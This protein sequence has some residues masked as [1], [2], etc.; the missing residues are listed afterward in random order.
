MNKKFT[1]ELISAFLD[2]E[3]TAEEK[4]FVEQ[5]LVDSAE[6]R[7]TFEELRALRGSL[8]SL[9]S[10]N[11]DDGFSERIL[12]R[13]ERVMLSGQTPTSK[14]E[15]TDK[16][17]AKAIQHDRGNWRVAVVVVSSVAAA[18]FISLFCLPPQQGDST[19]MGDSANKVAK[20][21]NGP[22]PSVATDSAEKPLRDL[23]LTLHDEN[24]NGESSNY[25]GLG[26]VAGVGGKSGEL[27]SDSGL[28]ELSDK[29]SG[30]LRYLGVATDTEKPTSDQPNAAEGAELFRQS[31]ETKERVELQQS[32]VPSAAKQSKNAGEP[33]GDFANSSVANPAADSKTPADSKTNAAI[34]SLT[35]AA[36]SNATFTCDD[37]F[38]AL[39]DVP[40][41]AFEKGAFDQ[42]LLANGIK[43]VSAQRKS[44]KSDEVADSPATDSVDVSA[45]APAT[46]PTPNESFDNNQ[47]E[48]AKAAEHRE[49]RQDVDVVF[50][51]ATME[52]IASTFSKLQQ[53]GYLL[54]QTVYREPSAGQVTS[55]YF[56]LQRDN[57]LMR[58]ESQQADR[59][60]VQETEEAG[61]ARRSDWPAPDDAEL[62][63]GKVKLAGPRAAHE[64]TAATAD[65]KPHAKREADNVSEN[66][67]ID[68][69]APAKHGIAVRV[70][71]PQ[72]P[73]QEFFK[74]LGQ[75]SPSGESKGD[76]QSRPLTSPGAPSAA[77]DKKSGAEQLRENRNRIANTGDADG[78]GL[79]AAGGFGGAAE[80]PPMQNDK[81][82]VVLVIRALPS[83]A[84][85]LSEQAPASE[86][87]DQPAPVDK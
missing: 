8:Q 7:R 35:A 41:E 44:A 82:R 55:D 11:L 45:P 66:E 74:S 26:G 29:N 2:G 38:V 46:A 34:D 64:G 60:S 33:A 52:Q 12:R 27:K 10:H 25:Y 39:L 28:E 14:S 24:T 53:D 6:H 21:T 5:Q 85:I 43:I 70:P 50:V 4:A 87:A 76:T 22:S 69:A 54:A 83:R 61:R 59:R 57:V 20:F 58:S 16:A 30:N 13:A 67:A 75:D 84:T 65:S 78:A 18:L 62:E 1:D 47:V 86:R 37:R 72:A 51:E 49:H 15:S 81:V 36:V 77:A 73:M 80:S 48:R 42:A 9:P 68:R 32:A 79:K 3:V 23:S 56:E 31:A 17:S 19:S 63:K 40:R 71:K